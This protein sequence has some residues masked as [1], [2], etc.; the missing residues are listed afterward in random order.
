MPYFRGISPKI[1]YIDTIFVRFPA[2]FR[3]TN[4]FWGG[5]LKNR[6]NFS[7]NLKKFS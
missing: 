2:F 6:E 5:T 7:E 1:L 4:L 3:L